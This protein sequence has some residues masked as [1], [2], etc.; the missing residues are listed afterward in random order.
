[1]LTCVIKWKASKVD[2]HDLVLLR[3][4]LLFFEQL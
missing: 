4:C 1:M 3:F 2:I